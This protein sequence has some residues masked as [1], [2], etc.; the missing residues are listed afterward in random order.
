[1][2]VKGFWVSA[3]GGSES[4]TCSDTADA[5]V[6]SDRED[7]AVVREVRLASVTECWLE[8][9]GSDCCGVRIGREGS[10]GAGIVLDMH[11]VGAT[12]LL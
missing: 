7:K 2:R 3:D 4:S 8:S 12:G 11:R 1:M 5:G 6:A 10:G 9:E